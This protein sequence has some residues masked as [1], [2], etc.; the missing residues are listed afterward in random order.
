M[1]SLKTYTAR[2]IMRNTSNNFAEKLPKTPM[3]H[4]N[5]FLNFYALFCMIQVDLSLKKQSLDLGFAFAFVFTLYVT[6]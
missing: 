4:Q 1:I 2:D 5:W 3:Q 6:S